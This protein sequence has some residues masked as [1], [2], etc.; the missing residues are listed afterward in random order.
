MNND[1]MLIADASVSVTSAYDVPAAP[2]VFGYR[3]Y[4]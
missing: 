3:R 4:R 1:L 2:D